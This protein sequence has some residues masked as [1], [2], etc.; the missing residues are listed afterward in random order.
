MNSIY[1]T[2]S[3][4]QEHLLKVNCLRQ[5]TSEQAAHLFLLDF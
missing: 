3:C 1:L 2:N 4:G 5:Q